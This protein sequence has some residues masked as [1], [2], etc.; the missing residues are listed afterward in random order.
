MYS[1]KDFTGESY[2][3][4]SS[5]LL[6]PSALYID[7]YVPQPHNSSNSSLSLISLCGKKRFWKTQTMTLSDDD[8]EWKI[9]IFNKLSFLQG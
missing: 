6:I 7:R 2:V 3:T 4:L 1:P 5:L 8:I 9:L